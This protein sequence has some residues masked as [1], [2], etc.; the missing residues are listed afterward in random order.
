MNDDR[1]RRENT[2]DIL[3][4]HGFSRLNY[5]EWG[6]PANRNIVI[7]V[8]GLTRNGRDFGAL[9]AALAPD[10]RVLSPD[11]PGRGKSDWLR[12][13]NDYVF[14]VYLGALTA[15][16]ARANPVS[17]AWVGTSMGGLLGM[18]MAGQPGTP[19][20]RLVINDVGPQIEQAAVARIGDYVGADPKFDSFAALESY[21]RAISAPFG[22][23]TDAQWRELSETSAR[24]L[25]DGRWALRYDPG[26]AVPF[27]AAP[28]DQSP[29]LW[30]LWDAIK[31]PT[32]LLRGA[33][34]DLLSAATA[35]A[36]TGRG[37]KPRLIEFGD[38]GHAPMLLD[39]AQIAPVAAFLRDEVGRS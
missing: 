31:C 34:S 14:P 32:L 12:D 1:R 5:Y 2:L 9:A 8:H 20:G 17:L 18:A 4:P 15:L 28:A 30:A 10:F 22:P 25:P 35:A 6:D 24:Q 7:C 27:R 37:P 3:T 33:H 36:M 13:P 23:L 29:L 11:M 39:P 21:I 38:V 16:V 19:I 26:I